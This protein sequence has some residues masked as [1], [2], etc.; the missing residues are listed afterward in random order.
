MKVAHTD[1]AREAVSRNTT[2]WLQA[3]LIQPS[4]TQGDDPQANGLAERLVGWVKAR[5]RLHLAAAGLGL[6]HWPSAMAFACAEHRHRTLQQPG[7]MHQFGQRVVYKSKHPTGESKKPFLRWEYATYLTPATRVDKGHLLLR[8]TTGAYLVARNVR[9]LDELVDPERLLGNDP[10]LQADVEVK[11]PGLVGEVPR[12]VTGKR[13]VKAVTPHSELLAGELIR[14]GDYGHDSCSLLLNAAFGQNHDTASQTHR[15]PMNLSVVMGAFCHGGIRGVTRASGAHP[16]LCRYLNEFLRQGCEDPLYFPRQWSAVMVVQTDEVKVHRDSRNEPGT[17][18]FVAAVATRSL[19]V[20]EDKATRSAEG[21]VVAKRDVMTEGPKGEP[22]VGRA[23]QLGRKVVA[24]DPKALHSLSPSSNWVVVGYTPL[25][26]HKLK[27]EDKSSLHGLGFSLPLPTKPRDPSVNKVVGPNPQR[28]PDPSQVVGPPG[29]PNPPRPRRRPARRVILNARYARIPPEEW[30]LLCQMEEDQF[31]AG[32]DRWTR[33]L[34]E[35]RDED[36]MDF[37][38]AS[39]PRGLLIGTL[40]DG[41]D[42]RQD[43]VLEYRLANG[44]LIPTA[45]VLHFTDDDSM[46]LDDSPFPDRL[47]VFNVWDEGRGIN[48]VIVI[49][50]V[51]GEGIVR[52]E[53]HNRARPLSIPGP[54]PPEIRAVEVPNHRRV[55]SALRAPERLPVPLPNP[56]TLTVRPRVA[57][58]ELLQDDAEV[59]AKKAEVATTPNLEGVLSGLTEPLCVTHTASQSEV[60]DHLQRWKSAVKKELDSLKGPGVL[61]SHYGEEARRLLA[62]PGTSVIPLKGVFTA[63]APAHNA[64]DLFRRKCRLVACG[65]QTPFTDVESLYASGAPAELVRAALV[66]ASGHRWEA[67]TCDIRSAFT[68]TPIP[69]EAGRRYVLRPPRWLIELGLA[70]ETECYTLGKVL[71]GFR[72]APAWWADFRDETLRGATFDGCRLVQGKVDGSIWR[73]LKGDLLQG[74]LIT[75]VDFLVLGSPEV[76]TALHGWILDVAKWETDGLSQALPGRPVRFL[77]MQLERRQDWSFAL[78]QEAYVDELIRAHGLTEE[79]K[80]RI[81]C[82]KEVIFGEEELPEITNEDGD[83]GTKGVTEVDNAVLRHAQRIAGEC[84]WLSQ[85]TRVDIAFTTSVLCS[86]VASNPHRA[87]AIGE[88]LLRYLFQTKSYKLHLKAREEKSMLRIFTDAS[89]APQGGHS[90]G[91]HVLEYRGSPVIWR[92]GRQQLIAMSSAEA[93][94]IQAV[95]GGTYGESFLAL[96]QDLAVVCEDT[97]MEVDNT[98]AIALIRGGGSQRTRHLKVRAAKLNQLISNGWKLGHCGG[99]FQKADILTKPLPLARLGFLCDLLNLK[100][101]GQEDRAKVRE[102]KGM[103]QVSKVCL[104]G[105]LTS[106]QNVVCK[107][108]DLKPALE[109]EW[110]WELLLATV[111]V[112]L[113][114][115]CLW[116]T[117]K[118]GVRRE[119]PVQPAIP[120]VRAVSA[121]ERR[122]KKLQERVSAA[123]DAVV[124]ESS[125]TASEETPLK[126][127]SHRNKCPPSSS[128]LPASTTLSPV[129]NVNVNAGL[130]QAPTEMLYALGVHPSTCDSGS[131]AFTRPQSSTFLSERPSVPTLPHPAAPVQGL[132]GGYGVGTAAS[133]QLP[134]VSQSTQTEAVV[135]LGPESSVFMSDRGHCAHSDSS[136]RGLRNAG[137]VQSKTVCHYCLRKHNL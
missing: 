47:M 21:G 107:G 65:N 49:R 31:E 46:Y 36:G 24:F 37:L 90:Y 118:K 75:Y 32:M 20:A 54:P 127:R 137:H 26:T 72:E 125:P 123:I 62:D 59:Y 133:T 10:P 60:R 30:R 73:I 33:V 22:Q 135:V 11:D 19:W 51:L 115:V 113:S 23:F 88:R 79:M 119:D 27:E 99:E 55:Q 44:R 12:R 34:E 132:V 91:G 101:S 86:T 14:A 116:E 102:V 7:L 128:E 100:P 17:R 71:Y 95:E 136:C 39:I 28:M 8:E 103:S 92:A 87:V 121:R 67:F 69:E 35:G 29:P 43:P 42:W 16:Q 93:E 53:E 9:G 74:Y 61:I 96:L 64:T 80:S 68:L 76:A 89:Y 77:G 83:Q 56:T 66:E 97:Q 25:G 130:A 82:P 108:E 15:G 2:E 105:V 6:E 84:L 134:K 4:F 110:P 85:R 129:V 3:H 48:E 109:V 122:S 98:A 41:R 45:T 18:N 94:L 40:R 112:I 57:Q 38:S 5:A 13:S 117:L 58:E 63:K 114:T 70:E 131:S 106:L 126:Q 50:V 104:V 124:S 1:R 78:D 52:E 120:K 81:T 111:L